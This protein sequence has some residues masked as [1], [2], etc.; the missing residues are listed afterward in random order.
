[1]KNN[2]Q[3]INKKKVDKLYDSFLKEDLL[4]DRSEYD[5]EDL[6]LAYPRL[7]K[8]EVKLLYLKVQKWKYSKP[9]KKKQNRIK[10]V[11]EVE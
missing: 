4:E 3:T 9:K 6:Q 1:M 7:N 11:N 10:I 8:K 2:K 5:E